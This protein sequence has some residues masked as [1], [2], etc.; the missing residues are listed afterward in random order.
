MNRLCDFVK[1][2][3]PLGARLLMAQL[4]IIAGLGKMAAFPK[5][6]AYMAN[7]GLPLPEVL[8]VLTILVEFGGGWMLILGW[9]ARWVAA[10]LFLFT[11]FATVIFHPFW[12]IEPQMLKSALNDFMKNLA[13]MGG[14]LYVVAYGAGPLSLG[15]DDCAPEPGNIKPGKKSKR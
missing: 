15:K 6:A 1:K 8:L 11:L 3:G 9:K 4:F 10:A 13:I 5:T 2:F 12:G 7:H 14:L